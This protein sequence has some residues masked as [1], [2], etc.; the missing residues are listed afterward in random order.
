VIRLWCVRISISSRFCVFQDDDIA[1]TQIF[2][3][4]LLSYS[5]LLEVDSDIKFPPECVL[6]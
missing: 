4:D 1:F 3:P 2:A 6:L 5:S